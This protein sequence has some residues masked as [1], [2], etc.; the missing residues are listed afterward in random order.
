MWAQVCTHVCRR[1]QHCVHVCPPCVHMHVCISS[2]LCAHVCTRV[3]THVQES[4]A[5]CAHMCIH[6]CAYNLGVLRRALGAMEDPA[7]PQ[8]PCG[9]WPHV[10][11]GYCWNPGLGWARQ[12][13]G[14]SRPQPSPCL[15]CCRG[16]TCWGAMAQ[17]KPGRW[18]PAWPVPGPGSIGVTRLRPKT[19]GGPCGDLGRLPSQSVDSGAAVQ[20]SNH[21][22][23]HRQRLPGRAG[24]LC[25]PGDM[26]ATGEP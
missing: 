9:P 25:L 4:S 1:A 13:P 20:L 21:L 8:D 15:L 2:A 19:P 11:H 24:N 16:R 3:H 26:V 7:Q 14:P 22:G 17:T 23:K 5:L 12:A 18:E 10:L 6:I